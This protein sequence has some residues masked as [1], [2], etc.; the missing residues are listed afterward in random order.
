MK[1]LNILQTREH[2]FNNT[3]AG[4]CN[5]NIATE[6]NIDGKAVMEIEHVIYAKLLNVSQLE[7]ATSKTYQEQWNMYIPKSMEN[8]AQGSIRIRKVVENE[9]TEYHL[10]TKVKKGDDKLEVTVST[11]EDN[12]MQ[13][14]FLAPDGLIKDRFCFPVENSELVWEIDMFMKP[15]GSYHEWCKIDLEVKD[16]SIELPPLPIQ[17]SE[18]IL[19][20]GFG[21]E[22][23]DEE[24]EVLI[25]DLYA[26]CFRSKNQY[27][28]QVK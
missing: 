25:A 8:A 13:F 14:K 5:R 2:H 4:M 17:F 26:N 10:T 21:R 3:F 7:K 9:N 27:V 1:L 16:K 12:F 20:K 23:P 24:A 18:V 6:D 11:T 19:P 22:Q 15:D 28:D